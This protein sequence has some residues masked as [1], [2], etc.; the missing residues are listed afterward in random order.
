MEETF[1]AYY[2]PAGVYTVTNVGEY[3]GQIS[4]CS[5]EIHVTEEGWEEPAE[6]GDVALLDVNESATITI[7][8]NQYVK[9]PEPAHFMFE[10]Q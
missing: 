3:M 7:G 10:A 1:Y 6:V 8:E 9:V 5:S 4:V 2:I